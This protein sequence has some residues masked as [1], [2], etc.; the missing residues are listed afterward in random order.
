VVGIPRQA[1]DSLLLCCASF[2]LSSA[3]FG[4]L[5]AH[6]LGKHNATS[7]A[8]VTVRRTVLLGLAALSC[9]KQ[10]DTTMKRQ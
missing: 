1:H 7:G 6:A 10:T 5:L 8:T 4:T 2:E 3:L 9:S